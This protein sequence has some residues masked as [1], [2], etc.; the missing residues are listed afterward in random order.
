MKHYKGFESKL[1]VHGKG[2][3]GKMKHITNV[4]KK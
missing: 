3:Y 4:K 1:V 2:T